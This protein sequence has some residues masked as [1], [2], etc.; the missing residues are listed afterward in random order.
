MS[1]WLRYTTALV[2]GMLLASAAPAPR[3][4]LGN[5][6]KH[7]LSGWYGLSMNKGSVNSGAGKLNTTESQFILQKEYPHHD[8]VS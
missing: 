3:G 1:R 6:A 2:C 8:A 7:P 4:S 5:A